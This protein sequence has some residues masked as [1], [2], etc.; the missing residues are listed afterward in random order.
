M[1]DRAYFNPY[2]LATYP[3]HPSTFAIADTDIDQNLCTE[4]TGCPRGEEH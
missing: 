4:E 3:S 2:I 1:S